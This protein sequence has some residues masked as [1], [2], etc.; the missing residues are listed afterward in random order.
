MQRREAERFSSSWRRPGWCSEG[1]R[2]GGGTRAVW[3]R[4]RTIFVLVVLF[5]VLRQHT[6]VMSYKIVKK[7]DTKRRKESLWGV[8]GSK[9]GPS[10][11]SFPA[12]SVAFSSRARILGLLLGELGFVS[13]FRGPLLQCTEPL[14]CWVRFSWV[15]VCKFEV[16]CHKHVCSDV[17]CMWIPWL[18][19]W[20]FW[21][22]LRAKA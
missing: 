5:P 15:I 1:S 2:R 7:D 3:N 9:G 4:E 22:N 17:T 20:K 18:D 16:S 6:G 11:D 10:M 12:K 21:E 8:T 14:N 19:R 13:L